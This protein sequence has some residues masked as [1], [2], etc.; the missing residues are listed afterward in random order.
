M[1]HYGPIVQTDQLVWDQTTAFALR[2]AVID[3]YL[4]ADTYDALNKASSTQDVEAAI[5]KQGVYW[6]NT[7]ASDR[8]GNAF[9]ADI[10]G[11][12]NVDEALLEAC[13]VK[14]PGLPD[15]LIVLKGNTSDCEWRE[16]SSSAVPGTLPAEKMPRGR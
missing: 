3:N 2:D 8:H 6:T 16:D 7:I 14:A 13:Q 1:T 11:T 5:S 15:R 9:Y 4:T 10:S 12:P